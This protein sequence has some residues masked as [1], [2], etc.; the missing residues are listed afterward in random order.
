MDYRRLGKTD[1]EVSSI[2]LGSMMWGSQCDE[3]EGHRQMDYA[4][5]RGV[6]FIDCAELY[7]V[8]PKPETRGASEAIIGSWLHNRQDRDKI[9]IASKIVGRFDHADWMRPGG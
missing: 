2:C 8:P 3:V 7:A 5:E 1:I 4:L 9:I 6:N